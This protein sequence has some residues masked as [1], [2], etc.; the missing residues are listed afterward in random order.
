MLAVIVAA[1]PRGRVCPSPGTL[2][3][4]SRKSRTAGRPPPLP[5]TTACVTLPNILSPTPNIPSPTPSDPITSPHH[6]TPPITTTPPNTRQVTPPLL[7]TNSQWSQ[8]GSYKNTQTLLIMHGIETN[9]GPPETNKLT[10]A[11][12][13]I[14]SITSANKI[15]ELEQFVMTNNVKILALTETKLDRT[16]ADSQYSI[17]DFHPPLTRHRTRHGGGVA[18]Y[19]HKSLPVQRLSIIEIGDEEWVWAKI[20]TQHFNLLISCIY[21]PP[22]LSADRL[23]SFL[24]TFTEA[25]CQAQTYSPTAIIS[26]GDFNTGNIYLDHPIHQHSGITPFDIKLKDT[27]QILDLHQIIDQPTRVTDDTSNLRDLI[28]TSNSSIVQHSGTLSSFA[29]LDHFPIFVV[30]NLEQP[31]QDTDEQ[32]IT[33]WDYKKWTPLF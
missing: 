6:N 4:A 11:H 3:S 25:I 31:I 16:V 15:D 32:F 14:N 30:L 17:N 12:L 33:V 5:G 26:L 19:V 22:N 10:I 8:L 24:D 20:K 28:F 21:L 1:P 9:P 18:L 29:H 27:A 23:Q 13:N 7:I 2:F